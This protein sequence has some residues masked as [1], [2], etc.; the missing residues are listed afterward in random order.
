[1]GDYLVVARASD[2]EADK[3][4]SMELR[5]LAKAQGLSVTELSASTWLAVDGPHP[6]ACRRVGDWTLIGDVF[7]H[8][9]GPIT[10]RDDARFSSARSLVSK[11]WGRYVGLRMTDQGA[12]SAVLRDPSGAQECIA[13]TDGGLTIVAST[14]P[15]WLLQRLRPA[16]SINIGRLAHAIRDPLASTGP[17]LIDG[18]VAIG[19]GVVQPLPLDGQAEPAW[20][21][22]E[23]A[24]RSLGS[25]IGPAEAAAMIRAAIDEAVA[26]LAD[27]GETLA[28]EVSGG[29]DSSIVAACLAQG[30]RRV[31]MWINA[32]GATPEADER[33][34]VAGLA[35]R[36]AVEPVCVPHAGGALTETLL[37]R[38]SQDVR[39]GLNALDAH[40]DLDWA[41]RLAA[42]GAGTLMT[43]K[44]G[45]AIL[46][47]S[48]GP[49]VFADA[50][51][52]RGWLALLAPD[53]ARLARTNE[54]SVW[55]MARD[56]MRRRRQG[57]RPPELDIGFVLPSLSALT[58]HPWLQG[59]EEF[60]PSKV[61][62]IAGVA[63][64]VARHARS[65]LTEAI[66]VRHPLCAQPVAEA[67]LALPTPILALGG[68]GRGLARQAFRDR[69]PPLITERRSKGDM[70]R[71]Y[72]KMILDSLD[73]LRPWLIDGRLAAAGIIDRRAA[74]AA[75]NPETLMWRG[76]Y[77][78]I[79]RA[80]AFEGWLRVWSRR[81]GG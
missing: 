30:G 15:Q 59:C 26:G 10:G 70:T 51:L 23:I 8:P 42:V 71:I 20:R 25:R 38:I 3:A 62:Q 28:A 29:L 45:D 60:G 9:G 27:G 19:P 6:P 75:L 50:W 78:A 65:I 17:L 74:E 69:L 61:F 2:G 4:R 81:L 72:G 67:C 11:V 24:H 41:C 80:A 54:M 57:V 22:A 31:G 7:G 44:G 16:W 47:H 63:D 46:V 12:V 48:A 58:L 5:G 37:E 52:D 18:P 68:R 73:M 32:Y 76:G 1:M 55:S 34:Y 21:P 56:A 49:D 66:D 77:S 35:E 13:W 40:H 79:I 43:G 64:N 33:A 39:P 14:V 36:L 53:T